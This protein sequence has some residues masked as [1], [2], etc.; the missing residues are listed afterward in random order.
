VVVDLASLGRVVE[1]LRR[2]PDPRPIVLVG[3]LSHLLPVR[4]VLLLRC[5][6]SVLAERLRQRGVAERWVEENEEAELLD[7]ILEES[8]GLHR[9]IFELDTTRREPGEVASWARRVLRGKVRPRVGQVDWL[10]VEP[11]RAPPRRRSTGTA[12]HKRRTRSS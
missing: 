3:H 2:D 4:D 11:P 9:R 7:V 5:R 12:R 6:P 10:A 8:V 1:R